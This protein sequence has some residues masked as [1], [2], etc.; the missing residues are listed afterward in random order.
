[1]LIASLLLSNCDELWRERAQGLIRCRHYRVETGS[2]ALGYGR[3]NNRYVQT[4]DCMFSEPRRE[5]FVALAPLGPQS[6]IHVPRHTQSYS[7]PLPN[8]DKGPN[9]LPEYPLPYPAIAEAIM[10]N[11]TRAPEADAPNAPT[12]RAATNLLKS[13]HLGEIVRL[14]LATERFRTMPLSKLESLV[15]PGIATGQYGCSK[16]MIRKRERGERSLPGSGPTSRKTSKSGSSRTRS[17]DGSR[18]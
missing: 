13:A 4:E 7:Q 10:P 16:R 12:E 14:M 9:T 17:R 1:M 2:T 18:S 8:S 11:I 6:T 3:A 5:S 15:I